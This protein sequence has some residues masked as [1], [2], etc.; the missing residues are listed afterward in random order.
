MLASTLVGFVPP[1]PLSSR[2]LFYLV[3]MSLASLPFSLPLFKSRLVC[4]RPLSL[5][6]Q[7]IRLLPQRWLFLLLEL[8]TMVVS[9]PALMAIILLVGMAVTFF[10]HVLTTASKTIPP[11]SVG[12]NSASL[13][14]PK[15]FDSSCSA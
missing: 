11:I 7:A 9:L 15:R 12:S 6:L 14:L 2:A 13:L 3:T 10:H 1:S 4:L 5:L 8:M